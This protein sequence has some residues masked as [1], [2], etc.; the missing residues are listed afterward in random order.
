MLKKQSQI[1]S[2]LTDSNYFLHTHIY[3]QRL[4]IGD[5]FVVEQK[6]EFGTES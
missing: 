6:I 2:F 1:I 3:M 4:V 5:D